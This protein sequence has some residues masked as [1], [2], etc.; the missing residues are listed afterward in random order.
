MTS[1]VGL[2]RFCPASALVP[3]R[4]VVKMVTVA[5]VPLGLGPG[6]LAGIADAAHVG[7]HRVE[8]ADVDDAGAHAAVG[9]LEGSVHR[10]DGGEDAHQG[11]DPQGNDGNGQG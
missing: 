10:V 1:V 6:Y 2:V 9:V 4:T 8:R 5:G 11:G 7:G 3:E